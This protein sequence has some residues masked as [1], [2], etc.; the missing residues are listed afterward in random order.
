MQEVFP[1]AGDVSVDS[2]GWAV[3]I[4]IFIYT[5]LSDTQLIHFL[6]VSFNIVDVTNDFVFDANSTGISF[7]SADRR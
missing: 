3:S 1:H 2:S 5:T 4:P 6:N 7:P